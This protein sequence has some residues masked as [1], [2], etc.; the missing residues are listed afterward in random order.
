MA[1]VRAASD[2]WRTSGFVLLVVSAI[3]TSLFFA[4]SFAPLSRIAF[5][6]LS[7]TAPVRPD[8]PGAVIVA[9]DEPSFSA[10]GQPWPWPR[11]LHARLI[12]SLRRAGAKTI[13]FDIL[14]SERRNAADDAQLAAVADPGTLFAVDQS[15][16]ETPEGT[17]LTRTEPL[18][19]FTQH[20][21]R[22]GIISVSLDPD[23]VLRRLPAYPDGFARELASR[24]ARTDG[25]KLIQYFG[26]PRT[27]PHVSY[28]Q[29]LDPERYLPP[30]TFKNR[31][32]VVGFALQTVADAQRASDTFETPYTARTQQL[33]PGAEIQATIADNILHGLW[34]EPAAPWAAFVLLLVGCAAGLLTVLPQRYG[35]KVLIWIGSVIALPAVSWALLRVDR[36]WVS[37]V[38]PLVG[39][40][41]SAL[42]L[43]VGEFAAE[44]KRRQKVQAAFGRYVAPEIV[45]RIV[46]DPQQVKLGGERKQI[47]VLFADVRGFTTISEALQ[48]K[49][50]ALIGLVNDILTPL[51]EIVIRNGG[52]IDKYIG[53]CLMAFWNAPLDD[54]DHAVRAVTAAIQMLEAI[55]VVDQKVRDT[56]LDGTT[57]SVRIGIGINTGECLV[58][59][60][61]SHD[62]FDYTVV[63]DAVNVAS[64]LEAM[65][66][67][68]E[69]PLL[70]GEA[71]VSLAPDAFDYVELGQ[72][73]VRGKTVPQAIYALRTTMPTSKVTARGSQ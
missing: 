14:L 2:S 18:D 30:N 70:V 55:E 48:T 10:I 57:F 60:M 17:L 29:A 3:L 28:Y 15:A 51:S 44:R 37:P 69:V 31:N 67:Q 68:K 62:R 58:G 46:A 53:D 50:E 12:K 71:T 9:I 72:I 13:A 64:R 73:E 59:N 63:G 47:T 35:F 6:F 26:G 49:P 56:H 21:A 24:E 1:W 27:Y 45:R 43:G 61:G 16:V 11:A 40:T 41:A 5:D 54:A 34:I 7:T 32:V 42:A 25:A 66:K 33:V 8:Q 22:S 52:T 36:L 23:G 65:T 19:I 39:M 20:G 4:G 38:E